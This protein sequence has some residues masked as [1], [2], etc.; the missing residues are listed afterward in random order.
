MK[1]KENKIFFWLLVLPVIACVCFIY[2]YNKYPIV[3]HEPRPY[4][5]KYNTV[6]DKK[7]S[8]VEVKEDRE[9]IIHIMEKT[10]PIFLEDVPKK[11]YYEKENFKKETNRSMYV[12]EFQ[13]V[14]SKYLSSIEDGHTRIIM[15]NT[16]YLDIDWKY[17][18]GKLILLD[19]NKR[20]TDKVVIEING[21]KVD[22]VTHFIKDLFPEENYVA[23][24]R[25]NSKFLK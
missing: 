6:L 13:L 24:S 7:L 12:Y 1:L 19:D 5:F 16:K 9:Q 8:K 15:N 14:L 4:K 20:L 22:K 11:Y 17:S 2:F 18:D 25:N 3:I 21:V 23:E 10:H